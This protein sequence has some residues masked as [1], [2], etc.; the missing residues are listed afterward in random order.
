M[1]SEPKE[2]NR[3][4]LGGS[5]LPQAGRSAPLPVPLGLCSAVWVGPP[6]LRRKAARRCTAGLLAVPASI[7]ASSRRHHTG[8]HHALHAL[9][10]HALHLGLCQDDGLPW[11]HHAS[12]QARSGHGAAAGTRHAAR[13]C[14]AAAAVLLLLLPWRRHACCGRSATPIGLPVSALLPTAVAALALPHGGPAIRALCAL[15][16]RRWAALLRLPAPRA[17]LA[18]VAARALAGALL[19]PL[20]RLLRLVALLL[21]VPPLVPRTLHRHL[22]ARLKLGHL[23]GLAGQRGLVKVRVLHRGGRSDG[24]GGAG[25]SVVRLATLTSSIIAAAGPQGK[26]QELHQPLHIAPA[27]HLAGPS[28]RP[29]PHQATPCRTAHHEGV[30]RADAS[31]GIERQQLLQQV[32]CVPIV[33]APRLAV[34]Q[35]SEAGREG[36]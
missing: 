9:S 2:K 26:T 3:H 32:E 5:K 27:S 33:H 34:L 11:R 13:R 30:L 15:P 23:A 25:Q 36:L 8:C 14:G 35:S 6:M 21:L 1:E 24:G 12:R 28:S 4:K 19:P 7:A 16:L 20:L 29:L 18:L 10:H 22:V 17:L 31:R